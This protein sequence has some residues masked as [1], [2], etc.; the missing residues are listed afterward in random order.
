MTL[1]VEERDLE[2]I[3]KIRHDIHQNPEASNEEYRTT[4]VIKSYLEGLEDIEIIDFPIKTGLV[5][6]LNTKKSG[7]T[8]AVRADIDA[9]KQVE[10]TDISYKSQKNGL[11]HA[12]GH[13]LHTA[14]LLALAKLASKN[15]DKLRGDVIFI[16]QRAEE[17]TKGAKELIDKG[18]FEKVNID[19]VLGFH[20][21]P[22]EDYGKVIIKK[23]PLMAGKI[24]FT[25]KVRGKGQHGS[26]PHLNID[27]IVC[28]SNIVMALQTIISR[29]TNPFS[30]TVLSVNSISGGSEENLVVDKAKISA[31]IRS[32][33]KNSLKNAQEK[34]QDLSKNI[35]KAY[36]C[37]I[38]IEYDD[39]IPLVYNDEFMYEKAL[40]SAEK[41]L[42]RE[43]IIS[44]CKTMA[45]EDFA[46]FMEKVPSFE[47]FFPSGEASIKKEALHSKKFFASDKT[48]KTA[49]EILLNALID[50]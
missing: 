38:S 29:N 34:M 5:A 40:K 44:D 22:E 47:Y 3:I 8:I 25:I 17:I 4:K 50:L 14:I 23:G 20:N 36:G 35:A 43:N 13:D 31:T 7:K 48:I 27:P 42:G 12:C 26:M 15:I 10:E 9:L 24:N 30:P 28:I 49:T 33:D 46:F 21:W 18:L 2:D 1:K 41:V 32:L 6:R 39:R 11:M 19:M 37:K 16:F 45:S